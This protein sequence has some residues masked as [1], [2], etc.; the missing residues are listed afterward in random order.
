VQRFAFTDRRMRRV[1]EPGD[2]QVWV[3]SHAAASRPGGPVPAGG[4]V[5]SGDGPVRHP[6][7]GTATERATV[8]VTGAVHE[9]TLDDPRL[10]EWSLVSPV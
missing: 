6:V 9:V 7:P 10:V 3:A 8:A 2:V 5:A 1:V 4:I